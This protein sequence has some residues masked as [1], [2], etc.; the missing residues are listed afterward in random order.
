MPAGED[1]IAPVPVP[2]LLTDSAYCIEGIVLLI[3]FEK[4][5]SLLDV[6]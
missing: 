5:L 6:S 3:S 4:G 2:L 1:V